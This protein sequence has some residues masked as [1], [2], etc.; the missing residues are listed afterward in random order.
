MSLYKMFHFGSISSQRLVFCSLTLL[1]RSTN[2]MQT[3]VCKAK[4]ARRD[5]LDLSKLLVVVALLFYVHGK[6][7]RSCREVS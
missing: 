6:H 2:N 4:G 3:E 5:M 1:S 7:L